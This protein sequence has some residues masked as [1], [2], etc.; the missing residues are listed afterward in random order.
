MTVVKNPYRVNPS[1]DVLTKVRL[2]GGSYLKLNLTSQPWDDDHCYSK[3][4]L[5]GDM[6]HNY[7]KCPDHPVDVCMTG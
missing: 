4:I 7:V 2:D 1:H 6:A 3:V 5:S